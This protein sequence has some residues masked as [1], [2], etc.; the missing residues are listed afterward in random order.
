M[1]KWTKT[2]TGAIGVGETRHCRY[3][4]AVEPSEFFAGRFCWRSRITKIATGEVLSEGLG[5]TSGSVS[6]C[7]KAAAEQ[8]GIGGPRL[9]ADIEQG[10]R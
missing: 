8:M 10:K 5:G 4:F 7:K 2:K 9:D 1:I 6:A 3:E